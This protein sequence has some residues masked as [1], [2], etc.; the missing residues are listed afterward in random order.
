[1]LCM[2][3]ANAENKALGTRRTEEKRSHFDHSNQLGGLR[4]TGQENWYKSLGIDR[5]D[6]TRASRLC[7]SRGTS[8][9]G[10]IIQLIEETRQQLADHEKERVKLLDR[11][12]KLEV[13]FDQLEKK[14][15]E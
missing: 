6:W 9:G 11:L 12:Q 5:A 14:Q 2:N 3:P 15:Q 4:R 1:M 10:I 7:N 13:L 8:C